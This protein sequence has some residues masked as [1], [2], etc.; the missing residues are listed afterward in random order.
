MFVSL[1]EFTTLSEARIKLKKHTSH[2]KIQSITMAKTICWI[3]HTIYQKRK[4]M[5]SKVGKALYKLLNNIVHGKTMENLRY[6][7]NVRL[8]SNKKDYLKWKSKPRYMWQ[9]TFENGLVAIRKGKVTSTR[10]TAPVVYSYIF[11]KPYFPNTQNFENASGSY[12]FR[13]FFTFNISN[14]QIGMI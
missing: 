10:T 14:Q 12:W 6:I 5:L 1:W 7:I 11:A 9:K 8:V 4:K 3:Q 2:I 13:C